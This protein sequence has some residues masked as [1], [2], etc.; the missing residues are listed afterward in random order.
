MYNKCQPNK[1]CISY[2]RIKGT[3]MKA[4]FSTVN[5]NLNKIS[6]QAQI[7]HLHMC[8]L[9]GY[10]LASKPLRPDLK[11]WHQKAEQEKV[12]EWGIRGKK[13]VQLLKGVKIHLAYIQCVENVRMWNGVKKQNKKK[14]IK[15][16]RGTFFR[17]SLLCS[18]FYFMR[19]EHY[20]TIEVLIDSPFSLLWNL[21]TLL[22]C[23]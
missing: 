6:F 21:T 2:K 15:H 7:E 8:R 17:W 4:A 12:R 16:F 22:K 19:K 20:I 18:L 3:K 5:I 1:K 13:A 9:V 11:S 14:K 23:T 10:R